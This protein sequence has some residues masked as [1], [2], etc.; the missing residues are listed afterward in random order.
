LVQRIER[1]LDKREDCHKQADAQKLDPIE[2]IQFVRK[3]LQRVIEHSID[4]IDAIERLYFR[5]TIERFTHRMAKIRLPVGFAQNLEIASRRVL[6]GS[7]IG[8]V[9]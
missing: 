1:R 9:A 8:V 3:C 7:K 5:L 2:R 6:L 4:A